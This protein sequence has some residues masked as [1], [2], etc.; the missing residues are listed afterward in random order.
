MFAKWLIKYGIG[1]P[2]KTAK[3]YCDRFN[4]YYR[5]CN[6]D[7]E[8]IL[9]I[10]F[11]EREA[12]VSKGIGSA[13][14]RHNVTTA[15][16]LIALVQRDF[17]YFIFVMS[18]LETQNFRDGAAKNEKICDLTVEVIY[19]IVEKEC[20]TVSFKSLGLLQDLCKAY[21]RNFYRVLS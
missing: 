2:G 17:T 16:K 21:A 9:K 11:A 15:E 3:I 1:S 20:S 5:Q 4:F 7:V 18:F 12:A 10:I 19:E 14:A 13:Q 8:Q 6:G